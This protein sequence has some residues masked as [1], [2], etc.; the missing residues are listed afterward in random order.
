MVQVTKKYSLKIRI[1]YLKCHK[2]PEHILTALP[3]P[4]QKATAL[5]LY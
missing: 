1:Y 5:K 2:I 3:N 4:P